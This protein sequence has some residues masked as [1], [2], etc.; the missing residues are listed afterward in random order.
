MTALLLSLYSQLYEKRSLSFLAYF[1]F[2]CA[3]QLLSLCSPVN[4]FQQIF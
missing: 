1:F 2:F 4:F 3:Y